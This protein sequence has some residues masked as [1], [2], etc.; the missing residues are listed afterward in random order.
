M[1][2]MELNAMTMRTKRS[3]PKRFCVPAKSSVRLK[4]M[5]PIMATDTSAI[6]KCQGKSDA[7]PA[8]ALNKRCRRSSSAL[9]YMSEKARPERTAN[10]FQNDVA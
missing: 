7:P 5:T 2:L 8:R 3:T 9:R 6:K 10:C 4:K 1:L